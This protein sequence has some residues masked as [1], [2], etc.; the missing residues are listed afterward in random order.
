[1]ANALLVGASG[2]FERGGWK[3]PDVDEERV[4]DLHAKIGDRALVRSFIESP[5]VQVQWAMVRGQWARLSP[6]TRGLTRPHWGHFLP[7]CDNKAQT[8]DRQVRRK[9]IEPANADLSIGEQC[10][11]L[12]VS[13]SSFYYGPKGESEV[14]LDLMRL[15]HCPGVE[16]PLR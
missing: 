15:I 11:L 8:L 1:M 5:L 14:K 9:M 3:A 12:P 16:T 4:K 10:K 7:S 6:T 13:Q 2:V